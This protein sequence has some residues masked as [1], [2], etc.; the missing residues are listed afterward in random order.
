MYVLHE[1]DHSDGEESIIG[2]ADSSDNALKLMCDYYGKHTETHLNKVEE[3]GIEWVRRLQVR[4]YDD[5]LYNVT[6]TCEYFT[7]NRA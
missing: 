3:S 7:L 1:K 2:V 6:V 4:S 5:S